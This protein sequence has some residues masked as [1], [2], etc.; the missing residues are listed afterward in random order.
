M[1]AI[2]LL[3]ITSFLDIGCASTSPPRVV[4]HRSTPGPIAGECRGNPL[5]HQ[6]RLA[7]D[8][9]QYEDA[10][11]LAAR[12]LERPGNCSAELAE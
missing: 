5:L 10:L 1:R 2:G 11:S 4:E 6:A 9:L 3:A 7:Y 12:A 8:D